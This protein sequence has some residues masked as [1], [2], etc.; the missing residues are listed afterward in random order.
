MV[1]K[2]DVVAGIPKFLFLF[3]HVGVEVQYLS[4]FDLSMR[5]TSAVSLIRDLRF[6][7]AFECVAGGNQW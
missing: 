6:P 1:Y 7:I 4:M 3:K 5:L 2:G